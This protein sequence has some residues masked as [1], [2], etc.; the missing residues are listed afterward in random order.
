[1]QAAK[2]RA[3]PIRVYLLRDDMAWPNNQA[4]G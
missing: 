4:S 1:M 2:D 3:Y